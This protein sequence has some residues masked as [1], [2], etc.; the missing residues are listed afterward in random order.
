[1]NSF[2]AILSILCFVRFFSCNEP[3]PGKQVVN[4]DSFPLSVGSTWKYAIYDSI[5]HRTDTVVVSIVDSTFLETG[6]AATMWHYAYSRS[7]DVQYVAQ[8][9]DSILVYGS[10]DVSSL[11][12]VL[13]LPLEVGLQWTT[14]PP[15]SMKVTAQ[16]QFKA[17]GG[18]S[19]PAFRVEQHPFIGNFYGGTT[20]WY[21]PDIGLVRMRR[22]W[23]DTMAGDRMN[24]MWELL[25]F[26]RHPKNQ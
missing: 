11:S 4:R 15:G 8:S 25:S 3:D 12:L 16:E 1:M 2:S 18:L 22:S 24:T 13:I 21:V 20:Y 14:S 26:E 23:T 19:L 7:S 17:P 9:G 6:T 10:P 5:K